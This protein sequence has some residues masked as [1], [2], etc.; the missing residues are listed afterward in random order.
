MIVWER[1]P[2]RADVVGVMRS[3][4]A[5]AVRI[6]NG[7]SGRVTEFGGSTVEH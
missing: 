1:P 3:K 5:T 2:G 4:S 7:P 6:Q